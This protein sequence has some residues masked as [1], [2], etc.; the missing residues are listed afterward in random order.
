M[1]IGAADYPENLVLSAVFA[2]NG[3]LSTLLC[4]TSML[5]IVEFVLVEESLDQEVATGVG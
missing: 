1:H 2:L 4:V 5:T 3:Q